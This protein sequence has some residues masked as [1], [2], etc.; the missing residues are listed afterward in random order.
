M[1]RCYYFAHDRR[2]DPPPSNDPIDVP[3]VREYARRFINGLR[4]E[5]AIGSLHDAELDDLA[6]RRAEQY[7]GHQYDL[8]RVSYARCFALPGPAEGMWP[9]PIESSQ[10]DTIL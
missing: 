1:D 4:A 6:Q 3:A 8:T 2:D 5:K 10:V 9:M 7:R